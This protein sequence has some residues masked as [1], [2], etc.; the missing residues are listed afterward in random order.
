MI[1][2]TQ[3]RRE[4]SRCLS[5]TRVGG[6]EI[7][8]GCTELRR[9]PRCTRFHHPFRLSGRSPRARGNTSLIFRGGRNSVVAASRTG[10][11]GRRARLVSPFPGR[12]FA[13][14]NSSITLLA[15]EHMYRITRNGKKR[16]F[17][18]Q[19]IGI[20]LFAS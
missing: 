19:I 13:L 4:N 8:K 9:P 1:S 3:R 5:K 15:F 12:A 17:R 6:G 16:L 10:A 18:Y 14:S 2:Y 11:P 20:L 7:N